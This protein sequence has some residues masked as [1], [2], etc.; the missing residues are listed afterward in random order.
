MRIL[1][2]NL[3]YE[4]FAEIK[5]R[6][7]IFEYRLNNTFWQKRII[8]KEFDAVAFKF[9]YPPN[10]ESEKIILREW[11][12]FKIQTINHKH[13]GCSDVSVFA[14]CTNGADITQRL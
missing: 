3:K 12:G 5:N 11:I 1:T 9:G 14:I 13:F 4:Y 10:H 2:L 6:S 8:G 7:K